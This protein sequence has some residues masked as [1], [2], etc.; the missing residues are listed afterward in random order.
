MLSSQTVIPNKQFVRNK[1]S[2]CSGTGY[3]VQLRGKV[4][5]WLLFKH[6]KFQGTRLKY[7]AEDFTVLF[8]AC[9]PLILSSALF[10][11]AIV[12]MVKAITIAMW[13]FIWTAEE[14]SYSSGYN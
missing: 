13:A 10:P 7:R 2:K 8:Q 12:V 3:A 4:R 9:I 5:N 14:P 1:A 11:L 6:H